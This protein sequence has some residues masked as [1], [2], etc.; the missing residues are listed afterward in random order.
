MTMFHEIY[1]PW[2]TNYL[3]SSLSSS[4]PASVYESCHMASVSPPNIN[5]DLRIKSFI[6][7]SSDLS[8]NISDF[9]I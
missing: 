6:E 1:M 4:H 7:N 5:I 3:P 9:Q 2:K 8:N